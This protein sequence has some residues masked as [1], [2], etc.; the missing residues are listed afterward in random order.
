[1]AAVSSDNRV[2]VGDVG[3]THARFA[4]VGY[5]AA[6]P[7]SILHRLDLA[8]PFATF[9]DALRSYF[10]R[11]GVSPLPRLAAIAVAGPVEAGTAR[12]TNRGWVISEQA[13]REMGFE[14]ALLI[15]DFAALA[16]AVDLLDEKHLHS[17]G[18]ELKRLEGEN[19][20]ILGAGTG[21]GVSC[22][23]RYGDRAVPMATE[24]GHMGF[25]PGD[26]E[27]LAALQLMWKQSERVSIERI[28]SGG[29]LEHLYR[30]LEQ[31][32]GRAAPPL[33]AAEISAAALRNEAGPRA[34]LTMFC[35]IFGAVAG[36]LA[37]A[38]GARGGV[39]I[40]GGIAEKIEEFLI[41]SPFRRRFEDKG[42]LTAYVAAIPSQLIVYPDIALLGAGRSA[43]L[44]PGAVAS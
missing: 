30:T 13:L 35:S 33:N 41:Q 8:E 11:S 38:H 16:L 43:I 2:L 18:P 15:N 29:G 34:A 21:F 17:I 20:T 6:G 27:E 14:R 40:A 7:W 36:D 32:A 42:R 26:A 28:L 1:L 4:V 5:S 44:F 10:E 37:L 12:F 39:Y 24:G 25:A 9:N 23:A 31:L 3:G 22:L 19:I